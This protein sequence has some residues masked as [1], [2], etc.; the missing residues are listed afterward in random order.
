MFPRLL[1]CTVTATPINVMALLGAGSLRDGRQTFWDMRDEAMAT[2]YGFA[3][4]MTSVASMRHILRSIMPHD[5]P[6]VTFILQEATETSLAHQ[7]A[8]LRPTNQHRAYKHFGLME[9]VVIV[10]GASMPYG[11]HLWQY[12]QTYESIDNAYV[13]WELIPVSARLQGTVMAVPVENHQQVED[14]QSL[15]QLDPH[16]FEMR[17]KQAEVAVEVAAACLQCEEIEVS[18]MQD[19]TRSSTAR[20][21]STIVMPLLRSARLTWRGQAR[22]RLGPSRR[23]TMWAMP[24]VAPRTTTETS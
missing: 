12:Y 1:G 14:G 6:A 10:L 11:L 5:G 20:A 13:T 23:K 18:M 8:V 17:I 9:L 19:S 16:N 3:L 2:G 22:E 7:E 24:H 15:A 4:L 21:R